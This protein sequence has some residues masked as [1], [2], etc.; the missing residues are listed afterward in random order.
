MAQKQK[1]LSAA[2]HKEL[3]SQGYAFQSQMCDSLDNIHK[4][5]RD[6]LLKS[7]PLL[8]SDVT[9]LNKNGPS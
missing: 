3:D 7:N 1:Q 9:E 8:E 4:I 5:K 6:K 2:I